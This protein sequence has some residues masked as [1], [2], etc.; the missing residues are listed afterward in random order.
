MLQEKLGPV[1]EDDAVLRENDDGEAVTYGPAA[2]VTHV[3][4]AEPQEEA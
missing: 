1:T 4:E 2:A 3:E